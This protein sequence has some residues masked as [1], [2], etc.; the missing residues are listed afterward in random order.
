MLIRQLGWALLCFGSLA[1]ARDS[2]AGESEAQLFERADAIRSYKGEARALMR[3]AAP[4]IAGPYW[5]SEGR[6]WYVIETPDGADI[7]LVDARRRTRSVVA[8]AADMRPS[9]DPMALD[10]ETVR[11]D[12]EAGVVDVGEGGERWRFNTKSRTTERLAA[13]AA[14]AGVPKSRHGRF[15]VHVENHDLYVTESGGTPRRLTN[16]GELWYSFAGEMSISNPIAPREN[17]EA[18]RV[19][20][21]GDGSR[22]YIER[23][24]FRRVRSL[25]HVDNLAT[26]PKLFTQRMAFPGDSEIPVPEIWVFDAARGTGLKIAADGWAFLGN[27]D[28]DAGGIFPSRDGRSLYFVRMSRGYRKVELCVADLSTGAVRVLVTEQGHNR[29]SVRFPEFRELS[30]GFIWKSDA[31][32][33]PHYYLHDANGKRIRQLTRGPFTVDA[34]LNVDER[35]GEL[36]FRGYGDAARESPSAK[37]LYRASLSGGGVRRLDSEPG[38]HRLSV[39]PG[40]DYI[41]DLFSDVAVAPRMVLRDRSG[42]IVMPLEA[43]STQPLLDA[44]W[45]MPVPFKVLAADG[46]TPLYGVMWLPFDF[47]PQRRYPIIANVYPGPS[48]ETV[49]VDFQPGDS[50]GALA[51]L[52]FVVVRVGQRGGSSHRGV[53]Y[54]DYPYEYGNARD[55]PTAD[56]KAALEQLAAR[57]AFIDLERVGIFGHSGGGLSALS[58][59]LRYPEFFRAGVASAGNHDLNVYEMNSEEF[60]YGD[61]K[62]GP[63]GG[64]Q[65]YASNPSEAHRLEGRLL[66]VQGDQDED[67]GFMHALRTIR[68]L[69]NAGKD[70]D[71]LIVPG[72]GHEYIRGLQPYIWH[73]IWRHFRANLLGEAAAPVQLVPAAKRV[74]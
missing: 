55:Y 12:P 16:D 11:F 45:K 66:I 33:Y 1:C 18:P 22:F 42:R 47:D 35:R 73:K 17:I 10:I 23:W 44:G 13:T 4:E 46:A 21:F 9:I 74:D 29:F 28:V 40:G 51:Q 14:R 69:E 27:M 37:H 8:R 25:Y 6:F 50:T 38:H 48:Q 5:L 72:M 19:H 62:S 59:M 65:G 3:R 58:G 31:D 24:D 61:V 70:F 67:V 20:W 34:I 54:Q 30:S 63:A 71:T 39:A 56:N 52:G 7:H 64:P 36:L 68:A 53:K 2:Q 41:V 60:H 57:H 43:G 49:P 15:E 32:G 26:P